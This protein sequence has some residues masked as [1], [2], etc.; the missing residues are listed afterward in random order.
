MKKIRLGYLVSQYPAIS[1]TFILHEI[2]RLRHLGFEIS[3]A[4]INPP[5]RCAE[6]LTRIEREEAANTYYVKPD[7]FKGAIKAHLYTLMTQPLG[8]MRGLFFALRLGQFDLKKI[9][10]GFFYFAEAVMIGHWM[11]QIKLSHLHVHFAMAAASVGLILHRTFP[12]KYSITVHGPDEFY[13]TSGNYLTPKILEAAFICC[14]SH[15]ARSQLMML[16]PHT[17]WD[18]LELSRL[19][20]DSK[21]FTPRPFREEPNP[22][23]VLCVGRLVPVKGQFILIEAVAR[24]ISEGRQLR[25]RF[26]GDGPDRQRLE[27]EVKQRQLT[28]QVVFEG[29]INQDRIL[30]FYNSADIFT[31]A[32]FAEGLPVVL[33]EAMAMEIPCITTHITGIP[34]LITSGKDGILVAASDIE[35]LAKAIALL[36]DNP[37]LRLKIGK[38][39]HQRVLEYYELQRNTERLADIFRRYLESSD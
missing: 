5:D 6:K 19:G 26:V 31:I 10:Y 35:A 18:K 37:D 11:R 32:S 2:R 9:L 3:V 30:D 12:I 36:M 4:S 28:E 13:D 14:I 24:L 39:G 15:F 27:D 22:Y 17:A 7:G 34:E 23:E 8:Y 33:M 20:V 25:L 29:A 38:S 21:I 16:S 1:H